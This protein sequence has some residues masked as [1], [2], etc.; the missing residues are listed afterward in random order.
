MRCRFTEPPN[1]TMKPILG[2]DK[3]SSLSKYPPSERVR[4]RIDDFV[5]R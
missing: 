3:P 2:A 4:E 1:E 5:T